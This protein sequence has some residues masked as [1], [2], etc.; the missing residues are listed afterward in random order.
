MIRQRCIRRWVTVGSGSPPSGGDRP[1]GALSRPLPVPSWSRP[2]ADGPIR[3][4]GAI[5]ATPPRLVSAGHNKNASD[6]SPTGASGALPW[7][8]PRSVTRAPSSPA[9]DRAS[10][11]WHL[12][13]ATRGPSQRPGRACGVGLARA[14][15]SREVAHPIEKS[16]NSTSLRCAARGRGG[17][18]RG[19]RRVPTHGPR[20]T[21]GIPSGEQLPGYLTRQGLS[22][23]P[24]PR[25]VRGPCRRGESASCPGME[26][27]AFYLGL[28]TPTSSDT[29][30]PPSHDRFLD[31]PDLHRTR[32]TTRLRLLRHL[33]LHR[34]LRH[35]QH[36]GYLPGGALVRQKIAAGPWCLRARAGCATRAPVPLRSVLPMC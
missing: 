9:T 17:P 23:P 5:A 32:R 28:G 11:S 21:I 26:D 29:G 1:T 25:I 27:E 19:S 18:I 13:P 22:D 20:I 2:H 3:A 16:A 7:V 8:H 24:H 30:L 14:A 36:G 35:P 34:A 15:G 12:A 6:Y 10:T 4:I 33:P 31:R